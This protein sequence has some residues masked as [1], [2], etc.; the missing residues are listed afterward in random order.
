MYILDSKYFTEKHPT[1]QN[2]VSK[3]E[4]VLLLNIQHFSIKQDT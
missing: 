4:T 1:M 2:N 3:F